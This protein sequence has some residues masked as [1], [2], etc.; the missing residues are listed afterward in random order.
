[1]PPSTGLAPFKLQATGG[2]AVTR[3]SNDRSTSRI[4]ADGV[5]KSIPVVTVPSIE[6]ANQYTIASTPCEAGQK[7]AYQVNAVAG[8]TIEFFQ[9][10]APP[11]GLFVVPT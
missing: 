6:P 8:L 1:M 9:M 5:D 7:V 3:L 2:I 11:L 4:S 10:T